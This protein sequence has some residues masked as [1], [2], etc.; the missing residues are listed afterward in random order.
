MI[1]ECKNEKDIDKQVS[2]LLKLNKALPIEKRVA[3][4]S[5]YTKNYVQRV[6]SWIED[7]ILLLPKNTEKECKNR[8]QVLIDSQDEDV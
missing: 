7:S 4:Q 5:L 3:M 6:L 2:M 1:S 8:N